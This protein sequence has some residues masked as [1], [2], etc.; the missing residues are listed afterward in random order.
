MLPAAPTVRLPLP[1]IEAEESAERV[2]VG[3]VEAAFSVR[4]FC[5]LRVPLSDRLLTVAAVNGLLTVFPAP[6]VTSSEDVGTRSLL[7]LFA[8]DQ[9]AVRAPPSHDTAVGTQRLS[10][11]SILSRQ[12]RTTRRARMRARR[13][14]DHRLKKRGRDMRAS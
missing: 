7:Q 6:I 9:F 3:I 2:P 10:S 13:N 4:L 8:S 1:V 11:D 12:N 5:R 14:M